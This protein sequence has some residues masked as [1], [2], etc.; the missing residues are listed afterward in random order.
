MATINNQYVTLADVMSKA[1]VVPSSIVDLTSQMN[2]MLQ[3]APALPC[4]N[5]TTHETTVRTGIAQTAWSKIYKG[6]PVSKGRVQSVS[7]GT[8]STETAI[9]LDQRILDKISTLRQFAGM[10]N[11][12][13]RAEAIA[14]AKM[15]SIQ[16]EEIAASEA[17]SQEAARALIYESQAQN[18]ERIT[19]L[20]QIFSSRSAENGSQ[21]VNAHRGATSTASVNTSVYYVTWHEMTGHLIYP[22]GA[23]YHAGYEMRP[24]ETS[25]N[26]DARGDKYNTYR[27]EMRWHLGLAIRDWRYFVRVA[28]IDTSS[29][30]KGMGAGSGTASLNANSTDLIDTLTD[31]Y[32]L[33]RGRRVA[34]G[35]TCM[36]ANTTVVKF[37]DFQARNTPKNL[38]LF[39]N[40]TG[41]NAQEV[42]SFRN[43][44][45]KESDAILN[46]EENVA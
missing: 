4:N 8:G 23:G 9:E 19:G 24:L 5:G 46:T 6:I 43:I 18:P 25:F 39:L 36:Y 20:A 7:H 11:P 2:P 38:Y 37:L 21:I 13:E 41:T 12:V 29:L 1:G 3:D 26:L 30:D 45:I 28:N 17:M 35:K 16:N 42:M 27:R 44:P 14:N 34:K 33:H 32:Y 31:A 40:Q 15:K 22:D 10:S